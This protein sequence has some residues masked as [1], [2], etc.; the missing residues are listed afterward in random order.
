MSETKLE[1]YMFDSCMYCQKVL[2]FCSS[3]G[4]QIPTVDIM[5]DEAAR[6]LLYEKTKSMQVPCLM[7]N[8]QPLLE[9]DDIIEYLKE[10]YEV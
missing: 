4:I 1:L 9:S 10:A 8:N 3:A 2:S 6:N 5:A 7:I